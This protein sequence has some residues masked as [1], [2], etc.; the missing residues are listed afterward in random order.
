MNGAHDLGGMHGLRPG[1]ARTERA[2]LPRRVG[3]A[4]ASRSRLAMGALG[5]GTS[6]ARASPARTADPRDYLALELLRDLAA[7]AR[8][9]ARRGGLVRADEIAAGHALAP[10]PAHARPSLDAADVARDARARRAVGSP[11]ARAGALSRSATRVR[12]KLATRRRI[13]GCRAMRAAWPASSMRVH[14]VPRLP[15]HQRA[16]PGRA[17]AISTPCASRRANS[18]ARRP[19]ARDSVFGRPLGR[20]SGAGDVEPQPPLATLPRH[21]ARRA[22]TGLPRA[23]GG[24]GLRARAC[25]ARAGLFTWRN[26][27]P[28]SPPRSSA[29]RPTATPISA[30]PITATGWRRSSACSPTL[31]AGD[32]GGDAR[33]R[34]RHRPRRGAAITAD[35]HDTITITIT[36]PSTATR[37]APR[38]PPLH[39]PRD[40]RH[41]GARDPLPHLVRD[42]GPCR[43]GAWPSSAPS[44]RAPRAEI[45]GA[46][47]SSTIDRIDAI[48]RET[49]A[50]RHRLPHLR[51]PSMS[52]RTA[53]FVHQGMTSSDVLD[54]C[55]AVQ[56]DAGG[57][58][59]A[60]GPRRAARR[61]RRRARIEHKQT[62]TIGRSHGIHAEPTT[63]GL[64]LAGHYAE[65]ARNRAR[66]VARARRDRDL[67][68]LRRGRHLRQRRSARRGACR[69][70][71]RPRGRAGLDAGHPARPPR[72]VLR[73]ARR[74]RQRRIERLATEIRHLQ[75]TEV[76]EAE[77]FFSPGP[78][79][80]VGDAAQAQPGADREP[81][82]ASRASCAAMSMPAM[83]NVALWHERDISH[84]RSSA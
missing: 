45:A 2:D 60:R 55:L 27:R 63:F 54:T 72:G 68:D 53:R 44:R 58:P 65:F 46:R 83:E 16:R 15:R 21:P 22:G 6:T 3:S 25:A 51:S 29:R 35:H 26:G 52:A 66:L 78:E 42:R 41:L 40:G 19:T 79:G 56:L 32:A 81:H 75:R 80:L 18:G 62:P 28:R 9:A 33:A 61:A 77:E 38:D 48:E 23:L 59:A 67:R 34:R 13:R 82:A 11:A 50:R 24:A 43:R 69:A 84:S 36:T 76:R 30:T 49:Q 12:A 64:K 31:E 4:R 10:P 1:R 39:P 57:R 71:A 20:L 70:Q 37:G 5:A 17:A 47:A 7:G 14:G 73:H 74:G 8:A